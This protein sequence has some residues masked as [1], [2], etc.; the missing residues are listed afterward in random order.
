MWIGL[1]LIYYFR[2]QKNLRITFILPILFPVF[3]WLTMGPDGTR[4]VAITATAI[5]LYLFKYA[6]PI[7]RKIQEKIDEEKLFAI[8][9][10]ATLF[11][12]SINIFHGD[13]LVNN[14]WI[15]E[16]WESLK[17]NY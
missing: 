9:L 8:A 5:V 12:P 3:A 7:K 6:P 14:L 2:D 11:L 1:V 15:Y 17:V 16:I 4:D 13:V 10:M